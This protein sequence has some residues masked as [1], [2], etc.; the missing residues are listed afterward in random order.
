MLLKEK[1]MTLLSV[2]AHGMQMQDENEHNRRILL[3]K[4][5]TEFKLIKKKGDDKD[6][7]GTILILYHILY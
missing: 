6:N 2:P 7:D 4:E 3:S 5:A 1:K